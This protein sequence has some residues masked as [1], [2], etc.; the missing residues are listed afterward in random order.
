L[1]ADDYVVLVLFLQH[2]LINA[3]HIHIELGLPAHLPEFKQDLLSLQIQPD[4][5]R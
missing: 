4:A 2:L 5:I 3:P 1:I